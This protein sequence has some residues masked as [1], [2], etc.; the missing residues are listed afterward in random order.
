MA[1]HKALGRGLDALLGS[2]PERPL[3]DG[4]VAPAPRGAEIRDIPVGNIKPNRHQPRTEFDP[5]SIE[6][7]SQSIKVHGLAQPLM[8]TETGIP[9]EYELVVG[10]RRLRASKLA[11][12]ATVPCTV[13]TLSNRQRFEVA[14]IENIQ[15]QDLNALE[16]AV[17]LDGLMREYTLT[18]EEVAA[19]IGKS[20][21]TV[22]NTLRLLRLHEHVQMAVRE[23]KIS[24]GHAKCL[25]GVA[26]HAEQL[27]L[28]GRVLNE[29]LSVR[30][31]EAL[32]ANQKPAKK[33]EA[34]PRQS[35]PEVRRYEEMF[36][37][38]L[39]R[40]VEL[41]TNGSKG[42]LKIEFYSPE[43]LDTLCARLGLLEKTGDEPA[44]AS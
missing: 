23:G 29:N 8:V 40:R 7:L 25:A 6:E 18:Q 26:D 16:E 32:V 21:S 27:R 41:K 3:T 36:Q 34:A 22:A 20:R 9:G 12:L 10:E 44:S 43:D 19:A 2:R 13:R 14:L 37:R 38:L 1:G 17:A 33:G 5:A 28:L 4:A 15:R 30:E 35:I 39:G 42:S 24:E 31:L 11:G